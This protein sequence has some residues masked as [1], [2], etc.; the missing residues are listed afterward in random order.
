MM[1][2]P[3]GLAEYLKFYDAYP[4]VACGL[5]HIITQGAA[6]P[7]ALSQH[8]RARMCANLSS[9][10]GATETGG[11]TIGP[12]HVIA[13]TPGA[14]GYVTPGAEVE[15]VDEND[16][17]FPFGR[18]GR[19]RLR[20]ARWSAAT[21]AIRRRAACVPGRLVLPRRHRCAATRRH[22]DHPRA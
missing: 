21:T 17:P 18:E 19:V 11:I 3:E 7:R 4:N 1:A 22:A 6:M 2:S 9:T 20:T 5:D 13:E 10:Y 8:V 16:A 15:I 12:A 14:A